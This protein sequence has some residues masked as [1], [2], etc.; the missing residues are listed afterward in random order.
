MELYFGNWCLATKINHN[1]GSGIKHG[2]VSSEWSVLSYYSR[3]SEL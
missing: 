3:L 2:S 1:N